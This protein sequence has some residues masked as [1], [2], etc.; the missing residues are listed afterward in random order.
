MFNFLKI[1]LRIKKLRKD[2][3]DVQITYNNTLLDMPD[4]L[5]LYARDRAIEKLKKGGING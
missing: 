3:C 5:I 2:N 4:F 1:I